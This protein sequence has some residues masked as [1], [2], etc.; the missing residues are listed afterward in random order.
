MLLDCLLTSEN[1]PADSP[2]EVYE[3][4][5]VF[6]CIWAFGGATYQD[7]VKLSLMCCDPS[8]RNVLISVFG[9]V[10]SITYDI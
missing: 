9:P 4:Y 3:T 1:F 5:F 7:Q 10:V 8:E 6:A 2:R